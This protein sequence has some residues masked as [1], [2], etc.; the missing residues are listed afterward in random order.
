MTLSTKR[1]GGA[2]ILICFGGLKVGLTVSLHPF[3]I[4][5]C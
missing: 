3:W 1:K 2:G 5:A 4:R